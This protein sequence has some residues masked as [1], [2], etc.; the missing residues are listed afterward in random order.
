[1]HT[2]KVG[3]VVA[4]NSKSGDKTGALVEGRHEA[5][6]IKFSK[7]HEQMKASVSITDQLAQI[8]LWINM[9]DAY[10]TNNSPAACKHEISK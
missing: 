3:V 8:C 4:I 1:M 10:F 2:L 9:Y 6:A 5:D 7:F